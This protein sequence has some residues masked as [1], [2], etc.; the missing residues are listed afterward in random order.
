MVRSVIPGAILAFATE[1][2]MRPITDL[3]KSEPKGNLAADFMRGIAD[4]L[5]HAM[6]VVMFFC[7]IYVCAFGSWLF[8]GFM[9]CFFQSQ[10][11][12]NAPFEFYLVRWAGIS[13]PLT[14]AL[15]AMFIPVFA[16]SGQ[17]LRRDVAVWIEGYPLLG[18]GLFVGLVILWLLSNAPG[19]KNRAMDEV[20][21]RKS[22]RRSWTGS[23][24]W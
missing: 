14:L 4:W 15:A 20:Y 13:T 24:C 18:R 23:D 16:Q 7:I 17:G 10:N 9:C 6:S 3:L 19:I 12:R 8:H 1:P 22:S 11:A 21:T 5:P 2:L